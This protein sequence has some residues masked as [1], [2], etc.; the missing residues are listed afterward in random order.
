MKKLLIYLS[1]SISC[2]AITVF[3]PANYQVNTLQKIE[4]IRQTLE[5][6]QQTQNQIRGLQNEAL[7][8]NKWAG[9]LLQNTIGMNKK[10]ID[11]LL[12]IKNSTS[13][14][15]SN[16]DS[17]DID[18]KNL[19]KQNY[20]GLSLENL[21][22]QEKKVNEESQKVVKAG[23]E[24]STRDQQ[25]LDRAKE[26][27]N[28]M[29]ATMNP[30]GSLQAQQTGNQIGMANAQSL[31]NIE[32]AMNQLIKLEAMK[33]QIKLQE[34]KIEERQKAILWKVTP[35]KSKGVDPIKLLDM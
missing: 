23:L 35:A 20:E 13:S 16:T 24:L 26:L 17:F 9:S 25:I 21:Q 34:A 27:Q 6:V 19:F 3:D 4:N 14:I 10:D 30:T 29:S 31:T 2:F 28:V 7:N 33:Q 11:N 15:L 8:L 22:F 12:Y 18:Y 32:L 5:Q 1:F